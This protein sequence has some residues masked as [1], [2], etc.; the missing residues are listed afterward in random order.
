MPTVGILS[1]G[2]PRNLLDSEVMI[3]SLK[4]SGFEIRN[5]EDHPD[6]CLINTCAFLES[7]RAESVDAII[8]ASELKKEGRIK[9]LV[10]CGCLPQLYKAKLAEEIREADLL[11]GTSDFPKIVPLLKGLIARPG[12]RSPRRLYV[13]SSMDYIYDEDAP[14]SILTP[15]HYAYVKISE[16]CSN[17]CSYCIISRL[18]G[19]FRSRS[20]GSVVEEVRRLSRGGSLKEVNLIGQDITL[21]GIDRYGKP[22]LPHLLRKICA[23]ENSVRWIRLLYTHPAHYT[24]ELVETIRDE[25]K[26]CK[27]IDLPIQHISDKILRA[28]NRKTTKSEIV[29]LIEKLR[30]RIPGVALRTSIIVGFPG[31]T[32]KDFRELLDF[33]RKTKFERLGAFIYSREEGT[34]AAGFAKQ[35]PEKAKKE[36]FDELMKLQQKISQDINR[37][38]LGKTVEVLLDEKI[39]TTNNKRRIAD[40]I[41]PPQNRGLEAADRRGGISLGRIETPA[42]RPESFIGRTQSDAPDV[43]GVVHVSGQKV[44]AGEFYKVRITD[45]LEYDLVGEFKSRHC[46]ER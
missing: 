27:Y 20:I 25:E 11:L 14:R 37:Y 34:R 39:R 46:E 24:D 13:S 33:L 26:I 1:L 15:P 2:C 16:G 32:E 4:R 35:I 29:A 23:L 42:F 5:I 17:F 12:A 6:I 44:K 22:A 45:T 3:G 36:R 18:R 30:N 43:D 21:F 19:N 10:I 41:P 40:F 31:E 7:A 28:M 8:E 38:Y 9:R